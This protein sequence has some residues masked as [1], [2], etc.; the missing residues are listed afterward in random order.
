MN[1]NSVVLAQDKMDFL[2]V[3]TT[4][5]EKGRLASMILLSL[6]N[7]ATEHINEK[8]FASKATGANF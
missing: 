6:Q 4:G 8:E 1:N 2:A 7:V 5:T 3:R